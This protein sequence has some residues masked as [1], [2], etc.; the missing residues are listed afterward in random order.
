[1]LQRCPGEDFEEPSD[2]NQL[3][4]RKRFSSEPP[5]LFWSVGSLVSEGRRDTG[6]LLV[7]EISRLCVC[8]RSSQGKQ[9][10]MP[11][12]SSSLGD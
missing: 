3:N 2:E 9:H 1:M 6:V 10:L 12:I 11:L 5:V 8:P 7:P 4:Q